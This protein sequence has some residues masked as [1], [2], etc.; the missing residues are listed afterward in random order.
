ML[1]PSASFSHGSGAK[2]EELAYGD[3]EEVGI[4]LGIN[5]LNK[6]LQ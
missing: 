6:D 1:Q 3:N 2:I 5:L 4:G